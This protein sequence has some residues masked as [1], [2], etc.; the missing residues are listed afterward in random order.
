MVFN[1]WFYTNISGCDYY[2]IRLHVIAL[3]YTIYLILMLM[4]ILYGILT[5]KNMRSYVAL[6]SLISSYDKWGC[7]QPRSIF[8]QKQSLESIFEE[9]SFYK[10]SKNETLNYLL[11]NMY[12]QVIGCITTAIATVKLVNQDTWNKDTSIVHTFSYDASWCNMSYKLTWT[13][14]TP[15]HLWMLPSC[16]YV[17]HRFH[18]LIASFSF[19]FC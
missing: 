19:Y 12:L 1:N 3:F 2:I 11:Y 9:E 7:N 18:W 4:C 16:L 6:T 8:I 17:I 5:H 14:R 13:I 15:G 10:V